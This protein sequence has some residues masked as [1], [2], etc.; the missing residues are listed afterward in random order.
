MAEQIKVKA[1]CLLVYNNHI[2]VADGDS[3]TFD[4]RPGIASPFYRVLGGGIEFGESAEDAVRR[5]IREEIGCEIDGLEQIDVIE[6]RFI[7]DNKPGHEIVFM[8][9]GTPSRKELADQEKIH[10]KEAG[11]EFDAVW[12]SFDTALSGEKPLYPKMD[13]RSMLN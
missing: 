10:V 6:N 1:M 5:E 9:K 4:N 3:M 13:Y 11:Y 7:Y 12:I 2:L 8:Y